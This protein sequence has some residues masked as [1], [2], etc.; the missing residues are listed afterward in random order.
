MDHYGLLVQMPN[1]W[2]VATVEWE[3]PI[4]AARGIE[5]RTAFSCAKNVAHEAST[6]W[7]CYLKIVLPWI[8]I[9]PGQ[10]SVLMCV[11]RTLPNF[12]FKRAIIAIDGLGQIHGN[13]ERTLILQ[14]FKVANA[15]GIKFWNQLFQHQ[16]I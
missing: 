14:I 2:S 5:H 7:S 4:A 15:F 1:S 6:E 12:V 9:V 10:S 3:G 13:H 8:E 16:L 11:C